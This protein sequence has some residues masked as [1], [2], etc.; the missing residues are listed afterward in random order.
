MQ[1]DFETF[2]ITDAC[3]PIDPGAEQATRQQLPA[4]GAHLIESDKVAASC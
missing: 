1:A 3:A 2:I 4:L